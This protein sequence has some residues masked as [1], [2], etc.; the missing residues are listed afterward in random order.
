MPT[1]HEMN[2]SKYTT[3]LQ[4]NMYF[5]VLEQMGYFIKKPNNGACLSQTRDHNKI[6]RFTIA[7]QPL[8]SCCISLAYAG[9]AKPSRLELNNFATSPSIEKY[10]HG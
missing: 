1:D 6:R 5:G 4:K 3:H 2:I 10:I 8:Q 7:L 9:Y